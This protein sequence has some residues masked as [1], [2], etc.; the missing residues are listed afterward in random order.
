MHDRKKLC[1]MV[2]GFITDP[3]EV[4]AEARRVAEDDDKIR[5]MLHFYDKGKI[6][7][8][9]FLKAIRKT[10]EAPADT[11]MFKKRF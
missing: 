11:R 6:P 2:S 4:I 9:D 7:Q 3:G 5:M 1:T 8:E 10:C